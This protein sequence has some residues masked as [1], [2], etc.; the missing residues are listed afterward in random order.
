MHSNFL[1][2]TVIFS[3]SIHNGT[4]IF[5]FSILPCTH[6]AGGRRTGFLD[7]HFKESQLPV[8]LA[9]ELAERK[10]WL[11]YPSISHAMLKHWRICINLSED[12]SKSEQTLSA[13]HASC[14]LGNQLSI[15]PLIRKDNNSSD[16]VEHRF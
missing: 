16:D 4:H 5:L 12:F 10:W 8:Y 14:V 2:R 3:S 9:C 7:N 15:H 13:E 6:T 1:V 11:I